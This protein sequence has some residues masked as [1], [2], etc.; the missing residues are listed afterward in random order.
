MT[1]SNIQRATAQYARYWLRSERAFVDALTNMRAASRLTALQGVAGYFR[2]AR[3]FPTAFDVSR[4]LPRLAPVLALLEAS[5]ARRIDN[6]NLAATV[7]AFAREL[8]AAYGGRKLLSAATKLLWILHKDYVVIYDS[9]ARVALGAPAGQYGDYL[10]RWRDGY[11]ACASAIGGACSDLRGDGEL[12]QEAGSLWDT[13]LMDAEQ[14]WFRRRA[15]DIYLWNT[16]SPR[17]GSRRGA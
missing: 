8:G 12:A 10:E 13:L 16:G 1:R 9:Q 7:E 4:G 17:V 11:G 3:N 15:Y 2:I 14:E 6:S 5:R